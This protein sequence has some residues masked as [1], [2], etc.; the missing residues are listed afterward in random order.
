MDTEAGA[1]HAG[2]MQG[3]ILCQTVDD[4]LGNGESSASV[5][6]VGGLPQYSETKGKDAVVEEAGDFVLGDSDDE[7]ESPPSPPTASDEEPPAYDEQV[8]AVDGKAG[9]DKREQ[10][11]VHYL[12]PQD[13]LLGLSL[14][15]GVEV[16]SHSACVA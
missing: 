5:A 10:L 8:G 14:Q 3:C 12:K 1:D 6:K 11:E 2:I 7:E 16:R 9:D 13:T 15:Y 4:V